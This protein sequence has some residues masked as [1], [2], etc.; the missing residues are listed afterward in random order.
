MP[1]TQNIAACMVVFAI[2][3]AALANNLVPN[4]GFELGNQGF[5]SSYHYQSD[6][7]PTA[8]YYI[9]SD[10]SAYNPNWTNMAR[11]HSG[12][13]MMIING[14]E[15]PDVPVWTTGPLNVQPNTTYYFSFY[16]T[17]V[18]P[19][20]PAILRFSINGE[21]IDKDFFVSPHVG[22]WAKACVP[23]QSP[24]HGMATISIVNENTI[25]YGNDFALDD[26]SFDDTSSCDSQYVARNTQTRSSEVFQTVSRGISALR[27]NGVFPRASRPLQ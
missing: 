21:A 3:P 25:Y 27:H 26:I 18:H 2:A 11:P 23:W 12:H 1:A 4:P 7:F 8:T 17:S 15:I 13:A 9:G 19:A 14:A 5:S 20:A 10:P 16:V 24:A 22:S 6:L